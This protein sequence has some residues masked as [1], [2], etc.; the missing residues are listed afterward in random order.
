[1]DPKRLRASS[2]S[3]RATGWTAQL[4]PGPILVISLIIMALMISSF[5]RRIIESFTS[6]SNTPQELYLNLLENAVTGS[7]Y[8]DALLLN[9]T[10]TNNSTSSLEN[11]HN[12]NN[13]SHTFSLDPKRFRGNDWPG[14]TGHTMVGHLRLQNIR[15]LL[16]NVISNNIKG[17]FA[18]F[19]V[20]RGGSCIFAAGLF[21]SMGPPTTKERQVHV[22][23]AFGKLPPETG[24]YGEKNNDY[25][26]V[27]ETQ[28]RYNFWKYGLLDEDMVKFHP[29]IFEKTAGVFRKE[30]D[31]SGRMIAVLR[32]DANFYGS[33][34][35]VLKNLYD[36]VST[37]GFV[38]FDDIR[39]H[40][41]VQR[42]WDDF[43]QERGGLTQELTFID[44]HSAYFQKVK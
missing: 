13:P 37:N 38:I 44:D 18:E 26:S 39:S 1:M 5:H 15:N 28:V 12:T 35:A 40:P 27:S 14:D 19:G 21:R 34:T 31:E 25:L 17:D 11:M 33:Y 16:F 36:K 7:L 9:T 10:T 42:A 23:D 8:N 6:V 32:I 22:F 43:L 30:L 29:G 41:Q 2:L 3:I 20:W 4:P 24:S